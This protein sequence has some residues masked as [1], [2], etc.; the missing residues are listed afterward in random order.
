MI[1]SDVYD[2]Y[3]EMARKKYGSD[4]IEIDEDVSVSTAEDGSG[5]WVRAWLWVDEGMINETQTD[6]G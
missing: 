1:S 4:D 6:N 2:R 5:A 3:V